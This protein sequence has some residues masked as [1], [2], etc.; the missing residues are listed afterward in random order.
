[1]ELPA[2]GKELRKPVTGLPIDELCD[3]NRFASGG[4][5][6]ENRTTSRRGEDD[7]SIGVPGPA[8]KT[9]YRQ[10]LRSS[11]ANIDSFY[12]AFRG[13]RNGLVVGRP[14]RIS[15]AVGARQRLSRRGS[16]GPQP[17]PGLAVLGGHEYDL[18][19]VG[20][21]GER[22]RVVRCGSIDFRADLGWRRRRCLT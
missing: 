5:N 13:K 10:R 16:N 6:T 7:D 21:E 22:Q 4:R 9:S 12:S 18:A 15:R 8:T 1:E 2:I 17:K 14:E 19:R 20:R 3:G 11:G